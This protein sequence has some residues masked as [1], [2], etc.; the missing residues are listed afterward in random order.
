MTTNPDAIQTAADGTPMIGGTDV[1]VQKLLEHLQAGGVLT[2]F[3][4]EHPQV[5]PDT[6]VSVLELAWAALSDE[7][8][9]EDA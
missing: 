6:A 8:A 4:S 1:P 7:A 5:D 9:S 3:V 2:D